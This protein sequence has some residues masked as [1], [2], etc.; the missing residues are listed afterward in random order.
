MAKIHPE[1]MVLGLPSGPSPGRSVRQEGARELGVKLVEAAKGGDLEEVKKLLEQRANIETVHT[2]IPTVHSRSCTFF[3]TTPL[4]FAAGEGHHEVVKLL[5]E[6]RAGVD[7]KNPHKETPLAH[8]AGRGHHEVAKLLLVARAEVD[9]KDS[10]QNT[11]LSIAVARGHHEVV[12]L[13]LEQR[14]GVDANLKNQYQRTLVSMHHTALEGHHE[15]VKLLLEQRAELDVTLRQAA[16]NGHEGA[17]K[18]LLE[19]RAEV[20]RKGQTEPPP[21]H[22][23]A[24]RGH[25]EVVKLLL[26]QR[27]EVDAKDTYEG[28]AL[29]CAAREV[30]HEVVKLLLEQRAEV[31][32]KD[33]E[34]HTPLFYAARGRHRGV[35]FK[36]CHPQ[37][38]RLLL[39]ARAEPDAIGKDGRTLLGLAIRHARSD[40]VDMITDEVVRQNKW[41]L[42]LLLEVIAEG[43]QDLI[44]KV[45]EKWP[46]EAAS[47]K[48]EESEQT[49][50]RA[51]LPERLR[52]VVAPSHTRNGIQNCKHFDLSSQ[53]LFWAPEVQVTFRC[54]PGVSGSDALSW[55]LLKNLADTPHD[56]IFETDAV[57]AM[58]LAA[59]LQY[60]AFTL[61]EIGACITTVVCLCVASYEYRHG[62]PVSSGQSALFLVAI[63]HVKKSID[64]YF[65]LCLHLVR[66]CT[67]QA[68]GSYVNFD[69]LADA[70][71]I[72]AGWL[73]IT[74][75][76]SM[77]TEE[78]E[79]PWMAIFSALAWLRLLY[80]LRGETWMGLRL[81]PILAAIRDTLVFFMLMGIC[82][83]SAVHAYYNLQVRQD[84]T[85]TYAAVLQVV[86][87]GVFGDFDLFEFEGLDPIYRQT[88]N[89]LQELEPIDPDPGSDYVWVHM[90]F[91]TVGVGI[92]VLLMNVLIGVLSANYELY[93][94]QS[95]VLF[96]RTRVKMLVELQTRPVGN[97]FNYCFPIL[98]LH[99][100]DEDK[101][102][103]C[104]RCWYACNNLLLSLCVFPLAAIL[105]LR[106]EYWDI[107]DALVKKLR[108]KYLSIVVLVLSPLIFACSLS[109]LIAFLLCGIFLRYKGQSYTLSCALG[110][111]D[112]DYSNPEDASQCSIFF[113]VRDEPAGNDVRSLR[114]DLKKHIDMMQGYM[115]KKQEA[116][117]EMLERQVDNVMLQMQKGFAQM[118]EKIKKMPQEVSQKISKPKGETP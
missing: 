95:A 18:L 24:G 94:D 20:N 67:D 92:T 33:S 45:I 109:I 4:S 117:Q 37:N 9:A 31:D 47:Q 89:N 61:L 23:A 110:L 38:A 3:Q 39:E 71:Y 72:V 90:L 49:L 56:G 60:R 52:P 32:A 68:T 78:L 79:K 13:L 88:A 63:F 43:N 8:A 70:M 82:I 101:M 46:Q 77:F 17:V 112:G 48:R 69:N 85:P 29:C 100:G 2:N 26:E 113:V 98:D 6:Q 80:S 91:Y 1:A 96:F 87:L 115:E 59:W 76:L 57:Q 55:K 65:Q 28:T 34:E 21:L 103:S 44:L 30:H 99:D 22:I 118:D 5:L 12:K 111:F 81:L 73:A 7:A 10:W 93:E 53:N 11:P 50:D 40:F 66:S 83:A 41:S 86:R 102:G 114:T 106:F 15:V 116:R 62:P 51:A 108:F 64:E 19:Q 27:A 107:A 16:F 84:P 54:L 25:H 36:E 104:R 74:R 14:A 42:R 97:L 75:Q 105:S 58:V 35:P